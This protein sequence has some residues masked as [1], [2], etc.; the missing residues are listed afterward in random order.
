MS[1]CHALQK[2]AEAVEVR[3]AGMTTKMITMA[4]PNPTCNL[5]SQQEIKHWMV[6]MLRR[7]LPKY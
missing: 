3:N 1:S 2:A 7:E 5:R 4:L 6:Q